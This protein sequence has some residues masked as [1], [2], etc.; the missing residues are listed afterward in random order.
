VEK[1]VRVFIADN[2]VLAHRV[3]QAIAARNHHE[4]RLHLHAIK[5]SAA[6]MGTERLTRLCA[7]MGALTDAEM[8]LQAPGLTRSLFEELAAARSELER[9]L[10][11]RRASSG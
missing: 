4:V 6:S 2:T 3:E 9:Y 11:E 5:G 8:R 10:R 7:T 1:L